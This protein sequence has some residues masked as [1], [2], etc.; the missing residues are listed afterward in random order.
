MEYKVCKAKSLLGG[1]QLTDLA[2]DGWLLVTAIPVAGEFYYYFANM[3]DDV[4]WEDDAYATLRQQA[5][6]ATPGLGE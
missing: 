4:S 1:E 6:E 3:K 5:L 2:N